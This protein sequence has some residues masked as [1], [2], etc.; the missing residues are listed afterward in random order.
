MKEELIVE[1]EKEVINTKTGEED[2]PQILEEIAIEDLTVDGICG[3][4]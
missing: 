3:V 4:Y 1:M 2:I